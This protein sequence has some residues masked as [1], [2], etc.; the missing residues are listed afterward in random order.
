MCVNVALTVFLCGVK[1]EVM[2]TV[3]HGQEKIGAVFVKKVG[4]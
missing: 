4:S 3:K 1:E 2:V